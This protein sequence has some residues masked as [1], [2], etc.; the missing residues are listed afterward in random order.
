MHDHIKPKNTELLSIQTR[1]VNIVTAKLGRMD[2]DDAFD[3]SFWIY[4]LG[5]HEHEWVGKPIPERIQAIF[6]VYE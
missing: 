3:A 1:L 6:D 4:E 2:P 5:D